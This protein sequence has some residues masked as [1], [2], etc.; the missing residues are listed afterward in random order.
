MAAVRRS[1]PTRPTSATWWPRGI[2]TKAVA[3]LGGLDVVINA[4]TLIEESLL[5]VQDTDVAR[6]FAVNLFGGFAIGQEAAEHMVA[7]G[8]GGTILY[9]AA[10]LLRTGVCSASPCTA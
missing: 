10:A 4:G 8:T 6:L 5:D 9:T 2:V 1:S 7:S 3:D